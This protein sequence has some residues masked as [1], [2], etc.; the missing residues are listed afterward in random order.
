MN[1]SKKRFSVTQILRHVIQIAAFILFP[2][3]FVTVFHAIRDI[4]TSLIAGTFSFSASAPS[5]LILG[6]VLLVTALWGRFFCGYFCAFGTIQEG[7]AF[8][9]RKL[10]RRKKPIPQ[11]LDRALKFA[12]YAVLFALILFVWVLQLPVDSTFS[13]WGVFGML[14]SGNLGVMG[15]AIPTVGF[16]ILVAILIVSFFVERFFC[17]YLCPLGALFT[18]LSRLRLFKIRRKEP[19]CVGCAQCTRACAM[20][21]AVHNADTVNSGECIDC[22]RCMKVCAPQALVANP[23]P[24]VAGT[25]AALVMGGVIGVGR[26]L[27]TQQ[28]ETAITAQA[29]D[30]ILSVTLDAQNSGIYADGVYTGS[31]TGFRGTIDAQVTVQNGRITDVTILSSRDDAEFFNKAKSGVIAAILSE[32][33]PNVSA[34]S[35]ATFSSYGIMEAVADALQLSDVKLSVVEQQQS[36]QQE[37]HGEFTLGAPDGQPGGSQSGEQQNGRHSHGAGKTG[38]RGGSDGSAQNLPQNNGGKQD[39]EEQ[40]GETDSTQNNSQSTIPSE[41]LTLSDGVYTGTGTGYRGQTQVTV[42]V[43]GGRITD[44]TVESYADDGQY[45]NRAQSGVIDAILQNQNL[46][47]QTVS[48]ATFSSNGILE[49]VADA[50]NVDFTNPNSTMSSGHGRH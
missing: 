14:V 4:V 37:S 1:E 38:K 46:N 48:G 41:P 35:G 39:R 42:T 9:S 2:G 8:L 15:A 32:Q 5:L 49:A 12:K 10:I 26:I 20:G 11:K 3:L 36:Q 28:T 22:M 50:L 27:P 44:I 40:N 45:F 6:V 30:S 18:P 7:L 47:V 21:I 23:H 17:R 29:E 25:A 33:Q 43:E 19:A 34:V 16:A 24:A 31:G 13:P